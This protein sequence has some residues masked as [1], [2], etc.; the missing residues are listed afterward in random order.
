M[1][2][3][4]ENRFSGKTY[5][6]TI[7]SRLS[8]LFFDNEHFYVYSNAVRDCYEGE[9]RSLCCKEYFAPVFSYYLL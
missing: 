8:L 9:G 6:Y 3:V 1:I 4:S 5:F 2:I 7:T